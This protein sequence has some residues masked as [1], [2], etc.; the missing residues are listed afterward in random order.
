MLKQD[1]VGR[2]VRVEAGY[3]RA[4]CCGAV[5]ADSFLSA[6]AAARAKI[7]HVRQVWPGELYMVASL[8]CLVCR[9]NLRHLQ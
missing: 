7:R 8:L 4:W 1:V 5:V 6:L 9:M 2:T 3:M